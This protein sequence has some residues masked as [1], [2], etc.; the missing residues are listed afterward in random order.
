[1]CFCLVLLKYKKK[2]I[3]INLCVLKDRARGLFL[4]P[5]LFSCHMLRIKSSLLPQHLFFLVDMNVTDGSRILQKCLAAC[6]SVVSFP[7]SI[8]SAVTSTLEPVFLRGFFFTYFAGQ[9]G[10]GYIFFIYNCVGEQCIKSGATGHLSLQPSKSSKSRARRIYVVCSLKWE[11]ILA[12]TWIQHKNNRKDL[13]IF[14]F[15]LLNCTDTAVSV[16]NSY[17]TSNIT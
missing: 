7:G 4:W 9:V 5:E 15:L 13:N 3:C 11:N 12:R 14:F 2:Y 16:K 17:M 8:C 6:E 1:M 10:S